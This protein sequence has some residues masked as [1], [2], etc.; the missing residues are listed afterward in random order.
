[1]DPQNQSLCSESALTGFCLWSGLA[2]IVRPERRASRGRQAG[3]R[4]VRTG[5]GC[6]AD[7]RSRPS[8]ESWNERLPRKLPVVGSGGLFREPHSQDGAF[9]LDSSQLCSGEICPTR[10]R[11]LDLQTPIRPLESGHPGDDQR[12]LCS[13]RSRMQTEREWA[14]SSSGRSNRCVERVPVGQG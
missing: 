10:T 5:G 4:V 1:M 6:I 11:A 12:F 3:I 9:G 7:E 2:P 8:T 14:P 13:R